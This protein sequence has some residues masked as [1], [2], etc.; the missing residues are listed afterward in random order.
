M[1]TR[2]VIYCTKSVDF[3]CNSITHLLCMCVC[4]YVCV[5]V[6]TR[7]AQTV[8]LA[9]LFLNGPQEEREHITTQL[10]SVFNSEDLDNIYLASRC[11]CEILEEANFQSQVSE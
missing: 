8:L 9:Y 7:V 6:C 5:C 4:V 3:M 10:Y 1:S 11:L 2:S